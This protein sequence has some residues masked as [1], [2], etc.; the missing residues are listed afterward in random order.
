M[1]WRYQRLR[2]EACQVSLLILIYSESCPSKRTFFLVRGSCSETRI[3]P[4]S[5]RPGDSLIETQ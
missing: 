2:P 5:R 1:P 4:E 3:A